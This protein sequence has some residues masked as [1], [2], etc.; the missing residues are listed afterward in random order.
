MVQRPAYVG[1][2]VAQDMVGVAA[3]PTGQTWH[4]N[5]QVNYDEAEVAALVAQLETIKSAL[6]ILESTG[7]LQTPPVSALAGAA[8]PVVVA[9]P[10]PVR[11]FAKFTGQLARTDRLYDLILAHFGEAVRS[12]MRPLWGAD[13]QAPSALP[14]REASQNFRSH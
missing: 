4:V 14:L 10:R 5:Y 11:D 7:G 2:D 1:I 13:T 9:N 12:P 8:A 6:V 3:L